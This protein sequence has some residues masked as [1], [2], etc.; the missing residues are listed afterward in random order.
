MCSRG[1]IIL[2][3][4]MV[5][6]TN[7]KRKLNFSKLSNRI[8]KTIST[9]D[10]LKDIEPIQWSADVVNGKRKITVTKAEETCVN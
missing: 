3:G 1:I 8:T 2:K 7:K 4:G 6:E 5:M 10:A 9:K